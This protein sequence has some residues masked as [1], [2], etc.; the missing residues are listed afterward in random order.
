MIEEAEKSEKSAGLETQ[1]RADVAV[2]SEGTEGRIPLC[3]GGVGE[4][5]WKGNLIHLP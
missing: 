1:G 2:L 3:V 5:R 4:G